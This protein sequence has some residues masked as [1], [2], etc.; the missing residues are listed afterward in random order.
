LQVRDA[1]LVVGEVILSVVD[2]GVPFEVAVDADEVVVVVGLAAVVVVVAAPAVVVVVVPGEPVLC[3]ELQAAST[4]AAARMPSMARTGL[5]D[6]PIKA[7]T[8][9]AHLGSFCVA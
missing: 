1:V 8:V 2:D 5:R 9:S 3:E 6:S 7:S 4:I